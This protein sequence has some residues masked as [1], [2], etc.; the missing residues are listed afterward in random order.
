MRGPVSAPCNVGDHLDTAD[1]VVGHEHV[2]KHR[3]EPFMVT[4]DCPR[5]IGGSSALH[6]R[7]ES[8]RLPGTGPRQAQ[9]RRHPPGPKL[10]QRRRGYRAH[11]ATLRRRER[12]E[13]IAARQARRDPAGEG[14]TDLRQSRCLAAHPVAQHLGQVAAGCGD[15]LCSDPDEAAP[16]VSRSW[17]SGTR[18]QHGRAGHAISGCRTE[19]LSLRRIA[20]RQPRCRQRLHSDRDRQA[21]RRRSTS[22]PRRYPRPHPG[23]QNR[24]RR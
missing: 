24:P 8:A 13:R 9:V 21:E 16:T 4:P 10:R 23:L 11:R 3:L 6:L 12:G 15:P 14:K 1:V 17:H 7:L 19:K 22:L 5:E 20:D 2:L 18:Q